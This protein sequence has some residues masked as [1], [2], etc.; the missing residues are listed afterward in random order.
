MDFAQAVARQATLGCGTEC[1]KPIT[2]CNH[3]K[4]DLTRSFDIAK[5]IVCSIV[6]LFSLFSLVNVKATSAQQIAVLDTIHPQRANPGTQ[7]RSMSIARGFAGTFSVHGWKPISQVS[8][9][10]LRLTPREGIVNTDVRLHLE[11][12]GFSGLGNLVGLAIGGVDAPVLDYVPESDTSMVI[13]THLPRDLPMGETRITFMFENGRFEEA[14]IV[15]GEEPGP[16]A[17]VIPAL[18]GLDP[19]EGKAGAEVE[20]SLRGENVPGLGNLLRV[21]LAGMDL[22]VLDRRIISDETLR[23]RVYLPENTPRGKQTI[24]FFFENAR[25]EEPFFVNTPA[26]PTAI[27]IAGIAVAGGGFVF[28]R[29]LLRKRRSRL[30]HTQ[31]D[32]IVGVDHGV[33][34]VEAAKS[35]TQMNIDLRFE[36]DV[37]PGEQSVELDGNSIIPDKR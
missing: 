36:I 11:G 28:G 20:L 27:V 31:L 10:L 18:R 25:F 19:R 16:M 9:V 30:P 8:P 12:E 29:R 21:N 1:E 35:S 6:V 2:L 4:F 13:A 32:F 23:I 26:F 15:R 7:A 3:I 22:R 33:Q 14:F 5:V 34:S 17:P 37:D 24:V